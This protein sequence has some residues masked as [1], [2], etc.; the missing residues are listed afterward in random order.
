MSR[1]NIDAV[2]SWCYATC[3]DSDMPR[4]TFDELMN[5]VAASPDLSEN[6]LGAIRRS[7]IRRMLA[8]PADQ[9]AAVRPRRVP[10]PGDFLASR[11]VASYFQ[12][13]LD[14]CLHSDRPFEML[15]RSLA[16]LARAPDWTDDDLRELRLRVTKALLDRRLP[17][18]GGETLDD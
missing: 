9:D 8:A 6:D 11:R 7:F 17:F 3:R 13:C 2:V 1:E 12:P 4:A 15:S 5:I 14:R 16:A 10:A 18:A